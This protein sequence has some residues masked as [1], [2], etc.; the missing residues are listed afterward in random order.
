MTTVSDRAHADRAVNRNWRWRPAV[1]AG[2]VVLAATLIGIASPAAHALSGGGSPPTPFVSTATGECPALPTGCV[3]STLA[4]GQVLTVT[5]NQVPAVATSFTLSLTDGTNQGTVDASNATAVVAGSTITY[6]MTGAPAMQTGSS[7]S[8][9]TL[10]ILAEGGVTAQGTGAPWNLVTSGEVD[11]NGAQCAPVYTRVFGGTNC[12]IGFGAAG[13]T[14]PDVYDVI[15]VPT[16]DLPGPPMDNAPEVITNCQAG[17]S[18]IVYPL[19][20]GGSLGQQA[21]GVFP[22]GESGIGNTTS[23]TLDYIPTPGLVSYMPVGVVEQIPGS[24]Y[25]SGTDAPPQYVSITVTG[26]QATFN[27]DTPVV[28]QGPGAPQTLSEFS[29]ASP[30]WSTSRTSL[31]YPS[32]VACP[33]D[34]TTS[35]IVVTY[36]GPI[37]TTGVRFKFEGFGDGYFVVASSTSPISGEREA[38]QSAYLGASSSPP[39]PTIS[40][41]SGPATPLPS[42]GG[43]ASVTLATAD[44][45]QCS[46]TATPGAGVQIS[47]PYTP[48][49]ANPPPESAV[50]CPAAPVSATVTVPANTTAAPQT[51]VLTATAAGLVGSVPASQT[52]SIV[53]SAASQTPPPPTTG[54]DLVASDG[55]IFTFATPF[56]GSGAGAG[57]T[58]PV[59]GMAATPDGKGYWL[60]TRGGTV[61]DYGSAGSFGSVSP[62]VGDVV[63]MAA[64][65]ATGGYWVV[66]ANGAV[67]AFNAPNDGSMAGHPLNGPIV[68]M[69]ATPDGGGYY[70]V[71]SDGGIFTFGD[72]Q[73]AGSMG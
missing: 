10:E 46:I 24:L 59:V 19:A 71:A 44:A 48:A 6:T 69:A 42:S 55:G 54:Y 20:G 16:A 70:L 12:S 73:F 38:S 29:Y 22:P 35:A 61:S 56:Y 60:V 21:C 68:G 13:P 18:D 9:S 64:D 23:N 11:K 45:T 62:L 34:S 40:Q 53:V 51:Y 43:S 30:W 15:A 67:Y 28:C 58:Q 36:P 65:S 7:L 1:V 63:G 37:P 8:L 27:Y 50:P 2:C 17:S 32:S 5:F 4:A 39:N 33:S 26:D 14:A 49:P 57:Q 52:L 3:G 47:I 72:A 31:V 41:F 25:V 66:G